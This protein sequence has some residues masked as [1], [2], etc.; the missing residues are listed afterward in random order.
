VKL[1]H[2]PL[3]EGFLNATNQSRLRFALMWANHD[4]RN[5]VPAPKDQEPAMLLPSRTSPRDFARVMDYCQE[6]YFRLT[7]YWRVEGKLYFSIFETDNFVRRLGGPAGTKRVLE[8]ARHNYAPRD[9][10]VFTL[11]P[12]MAP[13]KACRS[14]AKRV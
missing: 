5:Y 7:N 6:H 9:W 1:L 13:R 14:C 12:S 8:G 11:L 3:E 10:R 4:W 2:R